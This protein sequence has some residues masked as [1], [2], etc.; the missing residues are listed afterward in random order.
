MRPIDRLIEG[1]RNRS[2]WQ[3]AGLYAAG[4]WVALQVVDVLSDA[5]D[6]P[7]RFAAT[8]LVLLIVGFPI[9]LTTAYLQH[10]RSDRPATGGEADDAGTDS[11]GPAADVPGARRYLTWRNVLGAGVAVFA[12]WGVVVTGWLLT[13]DR[14]GAWSAG[15]AGLEVSP[16]VIA[17]FP[18]SVRGSSD[19]DHLGEGMVNLLGIKLDGAGDLRSVDSRALLSYL[20][21]E[22][23]PT[24]DPE[25]DAAIARR[26]GAGLFVMG[27]VVEAGGRLQVTA[28]LYGTADGEVV[29]Q[30]SAEGDDTFALVDDVATQ[31]LAGVEGPGARVRQIAAV[32]TSSLP[33]FR[34]YLEGEAAFRTFDFLPAYE[35][36]ERAVELD[37]LFAVAYYRLSVAAEWMTRPDAA[38]AAAESAVRHASRLSERDRQLLEAFLAW[39]TGDHA[40]AERRYRAILGEY[41]TDVE[42]W[43]QL[44][45]VLNHA[46]P[47]HGRPMAEASGAFETVLSYEPR[48]MAALV[49]LVR[50]AGFEGRLGD[51]DSLADRFYAVNPESDRHFEVRAIQ[52]VSHGDP[53]QVDSLLQAYQGLSDLTLSQVAW[54]S[55]LYTHND[56]AGERAAG[57]LT[58]RDRFTADVWT[59]GHAMR[60][61]SLVGRGRQRD[62]A[63]EIAKIAAYDEVSATEL[64]AFL[65]VAPLA[66]VDRAT[67]ERLRSEVQ[68]LD[69]ASVSP[70]GNPSF[71]FNIMEDR[72]EIARLYLLGVLSARLGETAAAR[73]YAAE[74][75][76]AAVPRQGGTV[77]SDLAA[78]LRAH[79]AVADGRPEEALERLE[80]IRMNVFYQNAMATPYDGLVR[81]RY[82]R[83]VLLQE[84]GR[85]EEALGW[86]AHLGEVGYAELS[87]VPAAT[88]RQA[89]ICE[90]LGQPSKA[91]EHYAAF[92]ERWRDADPELQPIV[93][94]AQ[95]NL[96]RLL[97]DSE[98][99]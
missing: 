87:Y 74:V 12:I 7:G 43:F 80:E 50:T 99:S 1:V 95:A 44:G 51:L 65:S 40:E 18:F 46:N 75:E 48:D 53:E 15:L 78:G 20:S 77:T 88:L 64:E 9:V 38:Q 25:R 67:L 90:A 19:Y 72:H 73:G 30:A 31:L 60:A 76:A 52:V 4:A 83:G 29:Q 16:S 58:S 35:A 11:R 13:Q 55:L 24:G 70:S 93:A 23:E 45:E 5:F 56:L 84:A 33:A 82:T 59:V 8:A 66:A 2:L 3:V 21:R 41:P 47:L 32:T 98:S 85:Y 63:A 39:R 54:N 94:E 79:A 34:A 37:T 62:A 69:L 57:L 96:R 61:H 10:R 81:E 68:S 49:H 22:G 91:A 14:S 86:L 6:L 89:E 92:V 36:F 26:F 27:D 28:A 71:F 17:V 42:A 97:P